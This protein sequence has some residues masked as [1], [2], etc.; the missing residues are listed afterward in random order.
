[1]RYTKHTLKVVVSE[2]EGEVFTKAMTEALE[3]IQE[4]REVTFYA[5]EWREET[6]FELESSD[7]IAVQL[8][9][10]LDAAS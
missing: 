7:G 3:R 2:E 4:K 8:A 5:T 9:L 10:K 1:M 6:M